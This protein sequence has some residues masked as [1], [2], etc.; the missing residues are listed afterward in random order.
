MPLKI[1][2]TGFGRTG[3]DSMRKALN[4]LGFSPTHHMFEFGGNPYQEKL[5]KAGGQILKIPY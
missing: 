1:I 5:L 3:T 4:M 2:G